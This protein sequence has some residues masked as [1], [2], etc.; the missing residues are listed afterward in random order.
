MAIPHL[1]LLFVTAYPTS[2][3]I[4]PTEFATTAIVLGGKLYAANCAVCH[5]GEGHGDGAAAKSLPVVPA[6]LTAEHLWAHSDGELFWYISHGFEAPEGGVTMPGFDGK[7]SIEARWNLIDYLRARNAGESMRTTGKWSH[8]VPV[9]QFDATCADGR[10]ID[11]DDLRGRMLRIVAVAD[12][13]AATVSIPPAGTEIRTIILTGKRTKRSKSTACVAIEPETW[14]AFAILLG[15]PSDALA[16]RQV[17]VDQ[18]GWLR[19][20]WQPGNPGDWTNPQALAAAV[21][22]IVTHPM[23]DT[24]SGH[25]HHH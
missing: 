5:G 11:L 18:N 24:V 21:R 20:Q 9:P 2:F 7:L 3:F 8:P 1:D 22:E 19:A 23:A 14:P 17:L 16:G 25:T 10:T 12:D 6:D 15:V 13:D 4:S